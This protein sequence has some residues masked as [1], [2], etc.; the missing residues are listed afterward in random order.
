MIKP[1]LQAQNSCTGEQNESV[2]SIRSHLI[3]PHC[4]TTQL[5]AQRSLHNSPQL[6]QLDLN[7]GSPVG[8]CCAS[9]IHLS[10][11]LFT[12]I[13]TESPLN[14]TLKPSSFLV[15]RSH[16]LSIW[17]VNANSLTNV[18]HTLNIMLAHLLS[19]PPKPIFQSLKKKW[20]FSQK[21][22]GI[23]VLGLFFSNTVVGK[24]VSGFTDEYKYQH[25]HQLYGRG[26]L[27]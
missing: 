16:W 3:L 4:S 17:R 10:P 21:W 19:K 6:F 12:V 22:Q 2:P 1:Y 9:L 18:T 24:N 23:S 25:K 7:L 27:P 20:R 13:L 11:L 5:L 14:R 8:I 15:G 26:H